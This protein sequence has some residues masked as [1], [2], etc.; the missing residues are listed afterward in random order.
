[1][2]YLLPE[3]QWDDEALPLDWCIAPT[4]DE[5][6][7]C[8]NETVL[9]DEIG[10][11]WC[12]EHLYRHEFL[13]Y[14]KAHNWPALEMKPYAVAQGMFFWVT[15]ATQGTEEMLLLLLC[16]TDEQKKQSA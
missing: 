5:H 11:P 6:G 13:E 15:A 1:M 3:D 8:R 7:I 16:A 4:Q 12:E 9:V 10:L 2:E 14:G